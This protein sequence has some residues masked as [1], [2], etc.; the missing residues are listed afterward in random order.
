VVPQQTTTYTIRRLPAELVS[1]FLNE[2]RDEVISCQLFILNN[3]PARQ[4]IGCCINVRLHLS[5]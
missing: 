5:A 2:Q 3:L 4:G 1:A